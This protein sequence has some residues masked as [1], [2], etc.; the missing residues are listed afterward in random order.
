MANEDGRWDPATVIGLRSCDRVLVLGNAAFLPWLTLFFDQHPDNLV[1]AKRPAEVE[2]LIR[3][4]EKFDLVV[5]PRDA[6]WSHD[7][8]LRAAAL[9]AK[10]VCFPQGDGWQI[11]QSVEFYYPTARS[12]SFDSTFG[13]VLIAE[14][15]GSSWRFIG[16]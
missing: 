13:P 12:W 15:Q 11:E 3:A 4:G 1:S 10:L 2:S 9:G 16:A 5:L 14:P 7:H 6:A 8:L